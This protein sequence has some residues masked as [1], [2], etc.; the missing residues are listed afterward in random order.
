M[1]FSFVLEEYIGREA[2]ARSD[3][4]DRTPPVG[5]GRDQRGRPPSAHSLFHTLFPISSALCFPPRPPSTS[6]VATDVSATRSPHQF[7]PLTPFSFPGAKKYPK[8][9]R[10]PVDFRGWNSR[11]CRHSSS[12]AR[13]LFQRYRD[14][15]GQEEKGA[16]PSFGTQQ[17]Q[18]PP[19]RS[20][21]AKKNYLSLCRRKKK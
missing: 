1:G 16:L 20:D 7:P 4:Y 11:I 19:P 12:P 15:K 17:S 18:K 13:P 9:G 8:N 3:A 2:N 14:Q 6:A 10:V 21:G 5:P